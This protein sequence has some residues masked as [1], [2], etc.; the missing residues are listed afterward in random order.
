M[1]EKEDEDDLGT[2]KGRDMKCK[3]RTVLCCSWAV[4]IVNMDGR[5]WS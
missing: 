4:S 1:K 5:V 2:R 3:M